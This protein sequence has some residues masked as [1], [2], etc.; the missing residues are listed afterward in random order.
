LSSPSKKRLELLRALMAEEAPAGAAGR[1]PPRPGAGPAPLSFGQE[2]LWFFG[3]MVPE[4]AV[5]NIPA[6]YRVSGALD[7]TALEAALARVVRRHEVLR[8]TFAVEDGRPLQRVAQELH[9]PV[10]AHD[11]SGLVAAEREAAALDAA[12]AAAREPF[13]AERGPLLRVTTWKLTDDDHR[14]L[15]CLHHAI[16]EV[17]SIGIL[18]RELAAEPEE[19]LPI[20]F[21]D[22]AVWQRARAEADAHAEDLA[23]WTERLAGLAE[24]QLA[25]DRPRPAVQTYAGGTCTRTF[26]ADTARELR[27][28]CRA[29][30]ATLFHACLAGWAALLARVTGVVDVPIG[31]P[32]TDRD[33]PE[34]QDLIGFFVSTL[35]LRCD[36]SGEPS[37]R[38]LVRR[39]RDT[40]LEAHEHR[41]LPFEQLVEALAPERDLSRSPLFQVA[42]LLQNESEQG[43]RR[44]ELAPGVVCEPVDDPLAAH[45]GTSK[46]DLSLIVW[47]RADGRLAA[48][49]E[50]NTDLFDEAR[51]EAMLG[52]LETLLAA[53]VRA[54]ERELADLPL[55]TA[56]EREQVLRS[57]NDTRTDIPDA[58]VHEL[59]EAQVDRTPDALAVQEGARTLTYRELDERANALARRLVS[60]G[61]GPGELVAMCTERHLELVVGILAALK[62]GGAYV[63]IDL[64]YPADRL[65]YML[66][67]AEAKVVLT[68]AELAP[69][70]PEHAGETLAFDADT[71][72]EGGDTSRLG[73]TSS[74]DDLAYA[75]YTSGSTG[76]PKGVELGHRGLVN[77]LTWHRRAYDVR[78]EDRATH[79]AGLA[80]DASVWELWPY[81]TTGSSMH[82]VPDEVRLSPQALLAWFRAQRIT[83]S[84]VPTPLAEAVLKEPLPQ[85]LA[86]EWMLTGGDK[87]HAPPPAGT[88]F[89]LVNHY[90]PTENTVVATCCEVP[91]LASDEP[92][93]DFAPPIGGPI[94]NV[95]VYV[96]DARLQPLPVGVPGELVIG[97]TSLAKGYHGRPDLTD[98]KF[99]RDPF[100]D[101]P[102]ARLYR[103][104]DLVRWRPDGQIEFLGRIDAQ[105][106][107]RGFRVEL[108]EVES[109]LGQHAG[110]ADCA[111]VIRSDP[112]A[113]PQLIGYVVTPNGTATAELR[114]HLAESLPDYMVPAAF[115][116][117]EALPLTPNGKVDRRALPEPGPEAFTGDVPFVAP[118]GE[119]EERIAA[120]WSAV[121]KTEAIGVNTNFFELGGHSLMLADVQVRLQEAIAPELSIIELFQ[122]PTV[123]SLATYLAGDGDDDAGLRASRDRAAGR[124]S[125][126]RRRRTP[127]E[128]S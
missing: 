124:R 119:L 73:R 54:P 79:L 72:H 34:T 16:S 15:I 24:L 37:F 115:V 28:F 48:S 86:L 40:A 9:V 19:P 113:G 14:L 47:D 31:A 65:A 2:R 67:D 63:P 109:V 4:S 23:W 52:Q 89:R 117:L 50:Y 68:R 83:Q 94:D 42:F 105:V 103:T 71:V 6:L 106:K 114:Q 66:A 33:R 5:F 39:A 17:Q 111:V 104:G 74:A 10:V 1:I 81:I 45:T 102:G 97:G 116:A 55:L 21:G 35:V 92:L 99:V 57:W 125:R 12:R 22:V 8:T 3:R 84:F 76:R 100:G 20:Q 11:L 58:P 101:E 126:M 128:R 25:G 18:L 122:Y 85:D 87:L 36:V 91:A 27:A 96:V 56:A 77:L 51:V 78:P 120:V 127:Q 62:A 26:A 46:F 80:F 43:E 49:F 44:T 93:A 90:G 53:A 30:G 61:V 107:V 110:V 59:F 108:G 88:P 60:S 69:T 118:E 75:I 123:R 70:L 38:T 41:D 29:E 13:D 64:T 82:L 7:P 95:Q 98:E 112:S 121:L 32:M